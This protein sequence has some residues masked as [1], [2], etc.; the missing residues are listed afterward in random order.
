MP[1]HHRPRHRRLG[2]TRS[3]L[4]GIGFVESRRRAQALGQVLQAMGFSR[5]LAIVRGGAAVPP[6]AA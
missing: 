2:P 4:Q 6:E 1:G 3:G 5:S